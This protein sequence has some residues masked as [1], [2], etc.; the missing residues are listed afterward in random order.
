MTK[1]TSAL[2][3]H[4]ISCVGKCSLTVALPILS[5]GGIETAV[6]PTSVLSTH[7]GGFTNY[8][9]HDLTGEIGSIMDHWQSFGMTFNAI[10]TGYL[11]SKAQ[12]GIM[13]D[14][15][16]RFG[17]GALKLV[18]PV[19]GDNGALYGGFTPDFPKGMKE[20]CAQADV[21]VP[22]FTEAAL[23]LEE[24]YV[25]GPYSKEYVEG[26]LRRLTAV[27]PGRILLTGV[28]FDDKAMGAAAFDPGL[29]T[30]DYALSPLAPG[31]YHGTGD[32]YASALLCAL[33]RGKGLGAAAQIAA[34]F[35][36]DSI[37]RSD[38][39][40]DQKLGVNFEVALPGLMRALGIL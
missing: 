10:Y 30:V 26:L 2:A 17:D 14:L 4:D 20:L 32:I 1:Q 12:L 13:L 16:S 31:F 3:V 5:A 37:R 40:R 34:D 35:T 36:A 23:L 15:F 18:D 21:I 24:P 39:R 27:C 38:P 28:Y 6:L 11:G 8:T 9:F 25:K 22:N 19:M 7:T 29:G 33:L